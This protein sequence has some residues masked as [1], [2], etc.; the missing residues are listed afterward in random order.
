M[1]FGVFKRHSPYPITFILILKIHL[2]ISVSYKYDSIFE[3]NTV[4]TFEVL[5]KAISLQTLYPEDFFM[6]AVPSQLDNW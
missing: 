4:A 3:L 2:V 1:C 6:D 5:M